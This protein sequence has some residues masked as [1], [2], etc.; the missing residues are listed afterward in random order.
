[1]R[2]IPA[3][4]V[5]IRRAM[6]IESML[7]AKFADQIH[8]PVANSQFNAFSNRLFRRVYSFTHDV[9][10]YKQRRSRFG[11]IVRAGTRGSATSLAE[12]E[13]QILFAGSPRPAQTVGTGTGDPTSAPRRFASY[14]AT[15]LI[16]ANLTARAKHLLR[17]TV[18]RD[19]K[20]I[21]CFCQFATR[22]PVSTYPISSR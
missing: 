9:H 11:A 1:M 14:G 2:W 13:R 22:S 5:K 6:S 15:L 17:P 19:A 12:S 8:H 21:Q 18:G 16:K 10:E 3:S 4:D 7:I 20:N